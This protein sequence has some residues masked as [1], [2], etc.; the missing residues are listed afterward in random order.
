MRLLKTHPHADILRVIAEVATKQI[1]AAN[2]FRIRL[3]ANAQ[4]NKLSL[5][6]LQIS[7]C[8]I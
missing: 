3:H 4:G 7:E 6:E 1:Q 5:R 2:V 8:D